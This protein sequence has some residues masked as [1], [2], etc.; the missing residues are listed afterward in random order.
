[1]ATE[2][3]I[4]GTPPAFSRERV[5]QVY[6]AIRP[7]IRRT[8]TLTIDGA[9]I[10]Y[11][12][13]TITLKLEQHQCAGSF[14]A[15]GAFTNL[16]MR[17]VP[18]SGVVAASGGNH[19][20]A[21]AYA[22]HRLNMPAA[23]FVPR[24]ASPAKVEAIR[25]AGADL[26]ITGERYADALSASEEF[27]A[28]TGAMPVHAFDT[29]FTILGQATLGAELLEQVRGLDA[30]LTAVGGGGLLAGMT[31]SCGDAVRLIGVEPIAAPT[32][33][34]ALQ[35]GEPVDAP[36]DGIAADSLAPRRVGTLT[37]GLIRSAVSDVLL[38][39][40]DQ[41]RAAQRVLWTAA[42][43][44]AEPGGAA[45]FAAVHSGVYRARAGEHIG[46]VISGG[47]TTALS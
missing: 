32:L 7:F 35:A 45:A 36:A 39:G 27:A 9:D 20:A 8:P 11:S 12:G 1:M 22:A 2:P 42:R 16:L 33:T 26:H 41:I 3:G 21:V 28:R 29:E 4:S 14:K 18:A 44:V 38:V 24:V 10:G 17:E 23:I 46:V 13:V 47:N 5:S 43:I 34:M 15:R 40:D 31:V 19:G 30:V 6:D 25:A 37:F